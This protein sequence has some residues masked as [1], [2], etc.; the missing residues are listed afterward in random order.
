M[1]LVRPDGW[2]FSGRA[3]DVRHEPAADA[4]GLFL[5]A[6]TKDDVPLGAAVRWGAE[7]VALQADVA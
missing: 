3:E 2:W 1:L 5:R 7:V 6:L 4:T